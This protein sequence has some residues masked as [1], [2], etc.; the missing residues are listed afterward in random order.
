MGNWERSKWWIKWLRMRYAYEHTLTHTHTYD[1]RPSDK[2]Q[3]TSIRDEV[4]LKLIERCERRSRVFS[5]DFLSKHCL[6]VCKTAVLNTCAAATQTRNTTLRTEIVTVR[7]TP[8]FVCAFVSAS[9][10]VD[11]FRP[12]D[13]RHR[14][15]RTNNSERCVRLRKMS[16]CWCHSLATKPEREREHPLVWLSY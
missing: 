13:A 7:L 1:S 12:T 10:A 6:R 15:A 3:Y 9:R 2:I 16:N 4:Q 5:L 11:R 14:I 8:F